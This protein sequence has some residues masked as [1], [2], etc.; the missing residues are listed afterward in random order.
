MAQG[1]CKLTGKAGRFVKCHIL[2][3]ALTRPERAGANLVQYG[4]GTRPIKRWTSWYDPRLVTE[5]GEALLARYDSWAIAVL[6]KH[7]MVWSS[8]GPMVSLATPDFKQITGTPWG[9]RS[10]GNCNTRQLRLFFLS[11][12]WRAAATKLPE[13]ADIQIQAHQLEQLRKMVVEGRTDPLSFFSISLTQLSTRGP[14]HNL[15]PIAQDKTSAGPHGSTTI[16]IFRIYFD[17][18]IAHL[19]RP[20]LYDA[21]ATELGPLVLGN[22]K[23]V[24]LSTISFEESFEH[25]NMFFNV[26][27][28]VRD[29]P[30]RMNSLIDVGGIFQ[31][32]ASRQHRR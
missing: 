9:I 27:E 1:H 3:E 29:W 20:G 23:M 6:R 16:P 10:I 32:L 8:W 5:E 19:H 18:L 30:E 21:I 7:K 12:L 15:A 14:V 25:T 2:P 4:Q 17:G 31:H 13:F 24:T 26:A 28:A 11:V 22:E